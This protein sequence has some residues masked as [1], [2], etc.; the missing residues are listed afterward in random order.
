[1]HVKVF[2]NR[3]WDCTCSGAMKNVSFFSSTFS[4]NYQGAANLVL[5]L[6]S[7][8]SLSPLTPTIFVLLLIEYNRH[9]SVFLFLPFL[10]VLKLC[11]RISEIIRKRVSIY[12]TYEN[13]F[14]F[15][16][17]IV[18]SVILEMLKKQHY[19]SK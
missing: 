10:S 9:F 7:T 2:K 12:H 3:I 4:P 1:M 5:N 6:H 14:I 8:R 15:N 16:L 13:W 19:D 18:K 17:L 11:I